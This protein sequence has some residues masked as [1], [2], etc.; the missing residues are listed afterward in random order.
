MQ[1]K[2]TFLIIAQWWS[3]VHYS[4]IKLSP[5]SSIMVSHTTPES[6]PTFILILQCIHVFHAHSTIR[7]CTSQFFHWWPCTFHIDTNIMHRIY[8]HGFIQK[9]FKLVIYGVLH[10]MMCAC[11]VSVCLTSAQWCIINSTKRTNH[12][13]PFVCHN[14]LTYYTCSYNY[15]YIIILTK[16]KSM[17][18]IGCNLCA[19]SLHFTTVLSL[20]SV[21]WMCHNLSTLNFTQFSFRCA[22]VVF[23]L[24]NLCLHSHKI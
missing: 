13:H 6:A 22:A 18:D 4:S 14:R 20:F 24:L 5:T 7:V 17:L 23:L 10:C 21:R 11:A 2:F 16:A 12:D 9:L 19:Q 15:L 8:H 3:S 1:T